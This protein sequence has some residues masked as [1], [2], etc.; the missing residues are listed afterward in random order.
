MKFFS[1]GKDGGPEST[2]T[3][4]FV[5]EIKNLFSIVFLKFAQG[6]REAF[7]SHAFN[8]VTLWLKGEVCEEYPIKHELAVFGIPWEHKYWRPGQLKYTPKGLSHR[9][10]AL[11]DSYAISI[12]GPWD[13]TWKE[14]DATKDETTTLTWGR[15]VVETRRHQQ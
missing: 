8:A 11:V 7:H 4:F 1:I 3:G 5:V 9:V 12:R 13:I 14:Y 6:T 15:K 2:V 10:R